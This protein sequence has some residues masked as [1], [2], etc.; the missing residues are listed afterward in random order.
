MAF[1]LEEYAQLRPTLW[2]LTHAKNLP[3]IRKNRTLLCA[4]RL[5]PQGLPDEPRRGRQVREG[6]PVL[7]DQ[8]L[9]HEGSIAFQSGWSMG[10]VVR[11]LNGRVF[12]WSG[13][14]DRPVKPG[15]RA[16]A[17]YST[18]DIILRVPFRDLAQQGPYFSRVNSGATRKQ[19][20]E[21]VPRGPDTFVRAEQSSFRPSAVV[22][23][24][25][26]DSVRMPKSTEVARSF[27]GPWERLY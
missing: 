20:G 2:H 8:D 6:V 12:F 9:L 4:A 22:E 25:F 7:R 17:R 23:V 19:G 11:D 10:D 13:W 1:T 3:L 15:R 18:T 27:K 26:L 16:F 14:I 24:A 21:A 5:V